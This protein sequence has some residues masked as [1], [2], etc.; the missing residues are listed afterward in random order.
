VWSALPVGRA[1]LATAALVNFGILAGPPGSA[2]QQL[3][4]S[5]AAYSRPFAITRVAHRL[6]V[7][8]RETAKCKGLEN[9]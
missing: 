1:S 9:A 5:G 2:G 8:L 6:R 3:G 4:N 7:C